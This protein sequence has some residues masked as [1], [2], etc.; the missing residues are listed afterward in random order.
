MRQFSC[1]FGVL[2]L[3]S[4]FG[5]QSLFAS[6]EGWADVHVH[7]FGRPDTIPSSVQTLVQ[8]MDEDGIRMVVV[9]P[10]PQ[11]VPRFPYSVFLGEIQK[12]PERFRFLGGGG[13]L[14]PLIQNAAGLGFVPAQLRNRFE[15]R[16]RQI[17]SD[18]AVGFGEMTA[19]HFAYLPGQPYQ[20]VPADHPLFLLLADIAA[21]HDAVIDFHLELVTRRLETLPGKLTRQDKNPK[22]VEPN[23]AE[24]ERLLAHN[25]RA[26]IVWAHVG[27]DY[28]GQRTPAI[29]A[30]L[31]AR[32]SNLYL[33][34]LPVPESREG[35]HE[36]FI[37]G[38][39][40]NREWL[41]VM[42]GYPERFVIGCDQFFVGGVG[43]GNP[44][45]VFAKTSPERRAE[46]R[47]L[48]AELPAALARQIGFEN[49]ARLYK[50]PSR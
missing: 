31:L 20:R 10:P 27:M 46:A 7:V 13:S 48:L 2:V 22:S 9:M 33:S 21:E 47:K 42:E 25:R 37:I 17:L 1:I 18:G 45:T 11:N 36:T 40:V 28:I 30:E 43:A 15:R 5:A 49:A 24:F 38:G 19:L 3:I 29:T 16:A 6:S 8:G 14:N 26:K 41:R 23:L 39:R 44:S 32:H 34:I 12:Y 50:L 35:F 4:A